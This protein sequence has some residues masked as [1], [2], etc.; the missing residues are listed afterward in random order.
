MREY[1]YCPFC[2]TPLQLG[3]IEGKERKYCPNHDFIDFR[4]PLPVAIAIAVKDEKFLLI[5]R[6][7]PPNKGM[8]AA[9]SGFIESGET[10]EEACLRE[11]KEET[12]LSGEII[13]SLGVVSRRDKELYGD[14]LLIR[15]LVKITGGELTPQESEVEDV[16]FFALNELPH[17][18]VNAF[19]EVLSNSEIS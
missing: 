3:V 15:Y 7:L 8:W 4:N 10:P 5:K 2:G 9:P 16:K 14:M 17:Y 12:G 18:Y 13:K 6:G 1:K 11:L 19:K